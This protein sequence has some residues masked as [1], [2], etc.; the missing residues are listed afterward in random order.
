MTGWIRDSKVYKLPKQYLIIRDEHK[1]ADL[2]REVRAVGNVMRTA[3]DGLSEMA[4]NV[5][6]EVHYLPD[7]HP[8]IKRRNDLS[9]LL[10]N[11]ARTARSGAPIG[12]HIKRIQQQY[13]DLLDEDG[14]DFG[15][16]YDDASLVD[17]ATFKRIFSYEKLVV[18]KLAKKGHSDS[19]E[20]VKNILNN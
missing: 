16:I 18:A 12:Q 17:D 2:Q 13:Q 11:A 8:D 15:W 4:E 20:G 10:T 5:L 19:E 6:E 1:M 3:A 7:S 9:R 14:L